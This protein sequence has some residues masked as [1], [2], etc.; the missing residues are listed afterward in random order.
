M[1]QYTRTLWASSDIDLCDLF[2]RGKDTSD[3]GTRM[4]GTGE[5]TGHS[6]TSRKQKGNQPIKGHAEQEKSGDKTRS[7]WYE[8]NSETIK[9]T[10]LEAV[11]L[12]T[13]Q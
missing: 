1:F 5:I 9:E 3:L 6:A 7:Y 2:V 10:L 11:L 8:K 12:A 13:V 4:G